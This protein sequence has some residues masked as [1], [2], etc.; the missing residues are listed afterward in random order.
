M[1]L[2]TMLES[3]TFDLLDDAALGS[4]LPV[5]KRR[6]DCE[7]QVK[8]AIPLTNNSLHP[9]FLTPSIEH[10]RTINGKHILPSCSDQ[11]IENVSATQ[12]S[13]QPLLPSPAS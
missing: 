9:G 3:K 8:P 12:I 5:Q 2:P 10:I 4:V 11:I 7:A 6:N 13:S 1:D